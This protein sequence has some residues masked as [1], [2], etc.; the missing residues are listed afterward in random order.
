[1]ERLPLTCDCGCTETKRENVET[2]EGAGTVEYDLHCDKC[3][4]YLGHFAY[5]HWE[6]W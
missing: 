2:Q 3:G 1:M 6:Y 5:G 4:K